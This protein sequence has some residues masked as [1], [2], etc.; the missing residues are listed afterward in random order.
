MASRPPIPECY[1]SIVPP[2]GLKD[3]EILSKRTASAM[4]AISQLSTTGS[5]NDFLDAKIQSISADLAV[6]RKFKDYFENAR[7]RE[8]L[9]DEDYDDAVNELEREVN[10]TVFEMSQ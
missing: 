3:M 6:N 7:N 4:A 5:T 1:S 10:P 9:A 8:A 2:S